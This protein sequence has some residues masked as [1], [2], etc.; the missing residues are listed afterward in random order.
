MYLCLRMPFNSDILQPGSNYE[1]NPQRL[2]KK[3]WVLK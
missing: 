2:D 3:H 1:L